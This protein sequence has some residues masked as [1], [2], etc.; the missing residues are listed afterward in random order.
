MDIINRIIA[1]TALANR[2]ST[3]RKCV[4]R[5]AIHQRYSS[6]TRAVVLA[7]FSTVLVSG[8][9]NDEIPVNASLS[10]TPNSH[11][12]TVIELRDPND[13]CRFNPENYVDIP[14]VMQLNTAD[15]SPIG[16]AQISV[17]ADFAAN[18][19]PGFPVLSLYDDL[20]GNGVV[21]SPIELISG[22][23]DD[24]ARVKTDEWSG[25]RALLLRVNLSCA[26]SGE[27]FA[28]AGGV[29]DRAV[30]EVIASEIG[31]GRLS[32]GIQ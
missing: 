21:D 31:E 4:S 20:N 28:F 6:A 15:G 1:Y 11:S 13:E 10:I 16:D 2:P 32:D 5:W 30:V 18:T 27:I 8:C 14:I 25:S 24:I 3:M 7:V 26:F 29:N 17:Y 23:D 22:V 9:A 19:F 12:T